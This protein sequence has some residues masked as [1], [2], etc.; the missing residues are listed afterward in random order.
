MF[1]LLNISVC[2]VDVSQ[3]DAFGWLRVQCGLVF[4]FLIIGFVFGALLQLFS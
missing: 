1:F 2:F 3:I 4:I